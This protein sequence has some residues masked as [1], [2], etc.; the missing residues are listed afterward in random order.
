VKRTMTS[1][2]AALV[3][4]GF[5][6]C[7]KP[8]DEQLVQ[9]Q[10]AAMNE[11]TSVLNTIQNDA[12]AEA[13]LPRLE[14]A[15]SRLAAANERTDKARAAK[16]QPKDPNQAMQ[17]L[18]DPK[19]QQAVQ[20]LMDAGFAMAA[21]AVQAQQKAP[22]KAAQIAAVMQKADTKPKGGNR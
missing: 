19:A 10:V 14:K 21:A 7:G 9:E 5:A 20:Q 2:L 3:L 16:P 15:V 11:V 18:N 4:F 17:Q 6:G 1:A 12:T 22:G 8:S 13:A